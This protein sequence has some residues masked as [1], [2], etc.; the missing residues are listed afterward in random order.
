MTKA[1]LLFL[2]LLVA[3][4]SLPLQSSAPGVCRLGELC[5]TYP[6]AIRVREQSR[7][8]DFRIYEFRRGKKILLTAYLGDHPDLD[9]VQNIRGR[10]VRLS[11]ACSMT[12]YTRPG[13]YDAVVDLG[14]AALGGRFVHVSYSGLGPDDG[15]IADQII[16]SMRVCDGKWR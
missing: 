4:C 2:L 16:A 7:R 10:K 11:A 6:A 14:E 5:V 9:A 1:P 3:S 15:R 13:A 8:L 12:S